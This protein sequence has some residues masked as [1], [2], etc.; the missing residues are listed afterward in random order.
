MFPY[1]IK[2]LVQ[3]IYRLVNVLLAAQQLY[4]PLYLFVCVCVILGI[5]VLVKPKPKP[6]QQAKLYFFVS[7]LNDG[8][9]KSTLKACWCCASPVQT[10]TCF[11]YLA[12]F[13]HL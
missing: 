7:D 6:N 12:F 2:I 8:K 10:C 4:L 13:G 1:A 5:H 9:N 3:Q 11:T